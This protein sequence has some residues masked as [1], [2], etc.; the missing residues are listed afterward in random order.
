MT[1]TNTNNTKTSEEIASDPSYYGLSTKWHK[2]TESTLNSEIVERIDKLKHHSFCPIC[3]HK[4]IV[5]DHY[6]EECKERIGVPASFS[7]ESLEELK[8]QISGGRK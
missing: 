2:A 4:L 8:T 3:L 6:C 5:S 1:T 7:N